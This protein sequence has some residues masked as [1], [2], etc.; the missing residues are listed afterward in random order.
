MC[1]DKAY[2]DFDSDSRL[3]NQIYRVE[4]LRFGECN[5]I[6]K[7]TV[8][9]KVDLLLFHRNVPVAGRGNYHDSNTGDI[10][11]LLAR[12]SVC[13]SRG[14]YRSNCRGQRHGTS[15]DVAQS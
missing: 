5:V 11:V 3:I 13:G 6:S 1:R 10:Q 8:T 14:E 9:I 2:K 4:T 15:V 12:R 7:A